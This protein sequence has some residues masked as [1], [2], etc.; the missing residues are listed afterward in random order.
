M[1]PTIRK[2]PVVAM[3][4]RKSRASIGGCVFGFLNIG[5]TVVMFALP[6]VALAYW[7]F[8]I[9]DPGNQVREVIVDQST[10]AAPLD[11][12]REQRASRS[13]VPEKWTTGFFDDVAEMPSRDRNQPPEDALGSKQAGVR[14]LRKF[15]TWQ[16][17][18]GRFTL[19]ARF[20][21]ASGS[22]VKLQLEDESTREVQIAKLG[23]A[24]KE[25]LRAV[26]KSKGARADF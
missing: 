22:M 26:F 13:P 4:K 3:K 18:S 12:G 10:K 11:R 8:Y 7:Y 25:Y 20:Y 1:N 21:S 19:K 24:D 5:L 14:E 2:I 9:R 16:D 15:R 23:E 17:G 6:S